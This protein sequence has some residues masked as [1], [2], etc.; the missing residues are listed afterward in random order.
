MI[1][2]PG[3]GNNCGGT[4]SSYVEALSLGIMVRRKDEQLGHEL[5]LD[6][7]EAKLKAI[8]LVRLPCKFKLE[9]KPRRVNSV[10]DAL[11]R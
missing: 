10:A 5:L 9:Y 3:E 8:S 11:N 2:G 7:K 6:V 1:H 4:L